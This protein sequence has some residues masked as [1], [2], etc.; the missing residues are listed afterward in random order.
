MTTL[1]ERQ[2]SFGEGMIVRRVVLRAKDV[3]FLKGVLEASE[4]LAAVYALSGGDLSIVSHVSRAE[5]LDAALHDLAT[6]VPFLSGPYA[7]PPT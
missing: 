1:P 4:G 3:V 2:V 5:E 6:E 7:E